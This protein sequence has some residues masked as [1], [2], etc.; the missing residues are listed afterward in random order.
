MTGRHRV[1]VALLAGAVVFGC[2]HDR[3]PME[4]AGSVI[5]RTD[6]G[7]PQSR[8]DVPFK[9]AYRASGTITASSSCPAGTLRVALDGDGTAS[10][11][12][13]Y[14]I[15]NSH[16]LNLSSG[17]FT[18]GT[19]VKTATNGDQLFGTYSGAG[20]VIVPPV[21]VGQFQV[22]GTLT[23]TGGTGRFGGLTGTAAMSGVQTTDFSLP[24]FPTDIVLHMDGTISP[25]GSAR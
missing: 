21:P 22:N 10:H 11:V 17:A 15:S 14:A 6:A 4:P 25:S 5:S 20:S 19:F 18:N 1:A 2:D 12:G 9:E 3:Q 13:R 16:C 24:D 8:V 7:T 23:F